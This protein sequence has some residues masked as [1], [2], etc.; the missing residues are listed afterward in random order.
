MIR[1]P[2]WPRYWPDHVVLRLATLGSVGKFKA[3]GTWGSAAGLLLY[4]VL[5]LQMG[6][7]V[8]IVATLGLC[9]VAIGICG[10]AERRL[11]KV[12]PG[13]VVF[14]EV[15]AMPLVFVGLWEPMKYGDQ[16]WLLALIGFG[17]FRLFD[18]WKPFGIKGLQ[19]YYGGFGVV[20]DDV[21]AALAACAVLN[22]IYW[23]GM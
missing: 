15:V 9:Y 2:R 6:P 21:V 22:A 3:P 4:V 23:F 18:I 16:A 14:D 10:E 8:G 17:L 19:R 7:L 20:I 12:D 1:N 5:I 13:E 11:K